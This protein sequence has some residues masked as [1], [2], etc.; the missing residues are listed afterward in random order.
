MGIHKLKCPI[1]GKEYIATRNQIKNYLKKSRGLCC[2]TKCSNQQ[3]KQTKLEKYGNENYNNI[4][5]MKQTKLEKYGNETYNNMNK[6]AQTKLNKYNNKNYNNS[7][8]IKQ[9]KLNKYNDENYNNREKFKQTC[10][11]KFGVDVPLKK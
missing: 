1:C 4:E 2:S 5:K 11:L 10:K 3:I 8:K 9:S 7:N 6:S